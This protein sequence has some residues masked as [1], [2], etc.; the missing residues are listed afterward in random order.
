M[1]LPEFKIRASSCSLLMGKRGM[2]KAGETYL[3][4]WAKGQIMGRHAEIKSKFLDKG[5]I[6]EDDALD[7][8]GKSLG[9]GLIMKNEKYFAN[10]FMTGTPDNIQPDFVIDVKNSWHW[11]TFPMLDSACDPAYEWQM[12]VYMELTGKKLAKVCYALMDTPDDLIHREA[13][14]YS[15][16]N[17]YGDCTQEMFESFYKKMTYSDIPE[18]KRI[19]IFEVQHDYEKI[20]LIIERVIEARKFIN[21]LDF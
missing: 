6:M 10:D 15:F 14:N 9:I 3:T 17:G 8:I 7:M 18:E 1:K 5:N 12:Q 4:Q 13:N 21:G 19:K 2:G 20:A 11:E 16:Y